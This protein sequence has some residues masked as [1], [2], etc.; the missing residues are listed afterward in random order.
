MKCSSLQ[1]CECEPVQLRL[2]STHLKTIYIY[3]INM[4]II[5]ALYTFQKSKQE[6][7]LS[8]GPMHG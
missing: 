8:V 3:V 5:K 1:T 2:N 6:F 4:Q 7:P